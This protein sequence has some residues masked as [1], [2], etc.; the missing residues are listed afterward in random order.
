MGFLDFLFDKEKAAQRKV[1]K[2]KK[3]LTN[4][5]TQPPE[6]KF[7]IQQLRDIGSDEAVD[8]LLA[9]FKEQ[10][11]NTTVDVDEKQYTY[12]TLVDMAAHPDTNV[13]ERV[14]KYLDENEERINWAVKV[15]TELL[16]EEEMTELVRRLL[17]SLD[18][19][20]TRNPEKKQELVLR[21]S[22]LEDRELSEEVARFAAD[23]DETIRFLAVEALLEHGYDDLIEE[24][25]RERLAEET[26]IRIQK[27]IAEAFADNKD[28]KIPEERREDVEHMLPEEYGVHKKGHIYR[29]RT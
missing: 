6:R 5:Y 22:D 2:Q 20:Y 16:D 1:D 25:L 29:V 13:R 15:L 27:K 24:T 14:E 4:M 21:A 9:R 8:A 17:S 18:T 11:P 7:A 28:W 3:T 26:S 12:E 23:D 10:A 19:E